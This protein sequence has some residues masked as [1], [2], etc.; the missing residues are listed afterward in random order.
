MGLRRFRLIGR[1]EASLNAPGA[2]RS[3]RL[4]S[5]PSD[6]EASMDR[7][8]RSRHT[9]FTFHVSLRFSWGLSCSARGGVPRVNALGR[10]PGGSEGPVRN[11][12][13]A[14][15]AMIP[16]AMIL[17]SSAA[18]HAQ[19][20][21][22]AGPVNA[23][24]AQDFSDGYD[25]DAFSE[26]FGGA[27]D[28]QGE[29][30]SR[31]EGRTIR[32]GF[33]V[34]DFLALDLEPD[35]TSFRMLDFKIIKLLE[36]GSGPNHHTFSLLEIPHL[37]SFAKTQSEGPTY[38]HRLLDLEAIELAVI[39]HRKSSPSDSET[40]FLKVPVLGSAYGQEVR[41]TQVDEESP[42][43]ISERQMVLYVLRHEVERPE[44]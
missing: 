34:F 6:C 26:E 29:G 8:S 32:L 15:L 33:W 2:Y 44:L 30:S 37:F 39:R 20:S 23:E 36:V 28:A 21:A 31:S 10:R 13:T 22:V 9:S 19:Q 16:L 43:E 25:E 1:T 18:S 4:I 11:P 35:R 12:T 38:E 42:E 7:S 14:A 24:S 27:V 5:E 17:G 3:Y 41:V 40:H